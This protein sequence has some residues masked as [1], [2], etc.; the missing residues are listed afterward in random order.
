MAGSYQLPYGAHV[1]VLF[2][3]VLTSLVL[4]ILCT[5][6]SPFISGISWLRNPSSTGDTTFGSF[7]WCSPDYCLPN[8]VAYEYGQQVNK[9]LTGGMMLW[10][11]AIIFTFLTW[12]A[13]IPLLFVH[14][15]KALRTVG[16]RIFF[17]IMMSI[18]TLVTLIAWLLSIYGWSVAHRAFEIAGLETHTG[19]AM[20][21]GLTAA[22]CMLIVWVLGWPAEAWDVAPT[23]AN[24]GVGARGL[25]VP[26][27][28]PAVPNNGY[29][30][31]KKT[32]REVVPRY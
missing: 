29:Y 31:Y 16:N 13:V 12:L 23:R 25:P 3:L 6:S 9:A 4:I 1:I 7:G 14:D 8:R 27:G 28:A 22:I 11:I 10:P 20:W 17:V 32:T 19:S 30:H 24:G 5:F 15:N 18:A 21:L 26:P 2:L